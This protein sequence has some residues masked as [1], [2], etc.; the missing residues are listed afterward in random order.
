MR[1]S[2]IVEI[3]D[4]LSTQVYAGLKEGNTH[5]HTLFIILVLG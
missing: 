2:L 1:F 4:E 5:T 3:E